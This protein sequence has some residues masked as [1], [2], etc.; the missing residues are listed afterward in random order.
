MCIRRIGEFGDF[1]DAPF[2]LSSCVSPLLFSVLGY[3]AVNAFV[4]LMH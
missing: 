3:L 1:G 2:Y 4:D